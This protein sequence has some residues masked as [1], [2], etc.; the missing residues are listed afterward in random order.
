ML[1]LVGGPENPLRDGVE[2]IGDRTTHV[3]GVAVFDQDGGHDG[4]E[5][6][7]QL[8][9]NK[10]EGCL[11]GI[12]TGSGLVSHLLQLA[13]PGLSHRLP[14]PANAGVPDDQPTVRH[15]LHFD[16][17]LLEMKRKSLA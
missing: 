2:N 16:F 6:V 7:V 5:D 1:R 3:G 11:Q 17:E 4:D 12:G 8:V 14:K 10:I 15:D 9:R 13:W